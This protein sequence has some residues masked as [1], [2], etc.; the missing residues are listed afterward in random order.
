[1]VVLNHTTIGGN[2]HHFVLQW[3]GKLISEL[4]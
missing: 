4:I 1:M 2:N 3:A